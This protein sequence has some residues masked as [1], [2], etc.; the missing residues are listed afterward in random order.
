MKKIFAFCFLFSVL[1][2]SSCQKAL[3]TVTDTDNNQSDGISTVILGE[4]E[5][6]SIFRSK[7]ITL[8]KGKENTITF[9]YNYTVLPRHEIIELEG[10]TIYNT[11]FIEKDPVRIVEGDG[12][13]TEGT[14]GSEADMEPDG[15]DRES[16]GQES[17]GQEEYISPEPEGTDLKEEPQEGTPGQEE[18]AQEEITFD[19]EEIPLAAFLTQNENV[20]E[21]IAAGMVGLAVL[22]LI[23]IY[24]RKK[25]ENRERGI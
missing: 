24:L 20:I 22:L 15:T 13:D 8:E 14:T 11:I 16:N 3:P 5:D 17:N 10:E 4:T 7:E 9:Y 1:M 6:I 21:W 23:I 2:L 18:E 19:E 25:K 12:D